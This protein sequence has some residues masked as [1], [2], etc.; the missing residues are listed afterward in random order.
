M[1]G[2]LEQDVAAGRA[3]RRAPAALRP[4]GPDPT[5]AIL[6]AADTRTQLPRQTISGH[7]RAGGKPATFQNRQSNRVM[8]RRQRRGGNGRLISSAAAGLAAGVQNGLDESAAPALD[9]ATICRDDPARWFSP[10]PKE[11]RLQPATIALAAAALIAI[12]ALVY[13][14][15]SGRGEAHRGGARPTRRRNATAGEVPGVE[16]MV[17]AAGR[18]GPRETRDDH[19]GWFRLGLP[20]KAWSDSAAV[21]PRL[22]ARHGAA[23]TQRELYRLSRRDRC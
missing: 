2:L 22:P 12:G 6:K 4:A 1:V 14:S 10:A 20:I 18:A 5:I 21:D 8:P 23:A 7:A 11:R 15:L 13:N 9:A 17:S 19:D 3:A 16:Q